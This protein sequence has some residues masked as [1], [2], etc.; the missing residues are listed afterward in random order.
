MKNNESNFLV[1]KLRNE[2]KSDPFFFPGLYVISDPRN[3]NNFLIC[4]IQIDGNI[5]MKPIVLEQE[6]KSFLKR[7]L[8]RNYYI[9]PISKSEQDEFQTLLLCESL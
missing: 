7:K 8:F 1:L 3:K 6:N 2:Y 4:L 9:Q 5:W